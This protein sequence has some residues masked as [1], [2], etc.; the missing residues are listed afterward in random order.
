MLEQKRPEFQFLSGAKPIA[1][2]EFAQA[3]IAADLIID[4]MQPDSTAGVTHYDATTM[5]K[6]PAW[7]VKAKQTL[8]LGRNVFFKD[9]P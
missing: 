8:R 2:C 5:P 4:G 9:V 7:A 3:R 6:P 1:F